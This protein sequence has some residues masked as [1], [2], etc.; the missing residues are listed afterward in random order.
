M[1]E[2]LG[3]VLDALDRLRPGSV[4]PGGT[5]L[6]A[7]LDTAIEAVAIDPQQHAQGRA[8]VI[9]SDG[10]DHADR[11][12][13]RLERLR[14][15]DIVVHAVSIGDADE[16]HPVPTG[17]TAEP[18]KFEGQTVLSKRVD[19]YLDTIARGSGGT[20]VKLGLSS[21]DLGA[22]RV[23]SRAARPPPAPG[24]AACRQGRAVP[25]VLVDGLRNAHRRLFARESELA[26]ELYLVLE[27]AAALE[28]AACL[29]SSRS[30]LVNDRG[31][32]RDRCRDRR[33]ASPRR[34]GAVGCGPG[35][36]SLRCRA[37]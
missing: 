36:D 28:L 12:S 37:V 11:W 7:A 18:L 6:A 31:D 32:F 21:T 4:T 10:E 14:Q 23:E 15:Q 17:N 29:A 22:L 5:D 8:I 13:S 33:A 27:L 1:T 19:T 3:A 30:R 16:G 9:F 2:N 24:H 25:P 34:I 35:K 26:L 20:I